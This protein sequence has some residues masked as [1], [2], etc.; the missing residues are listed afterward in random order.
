VE[1]S[2]EQIEAFGAIFPDNHRPVQP[3]NNRQILTNS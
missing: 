2:K 1:M 3:L